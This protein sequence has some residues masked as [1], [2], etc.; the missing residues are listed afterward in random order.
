M[1]KNWPAKHAKY[2]VKP[3]CLTTLHLSLCFSMFSLFSGKRDY[4]L[5][6]DFCFQRFSVSAF[7]MFP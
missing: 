5:Q 4:G 1:G 3:E 6:A 7:G 2:E